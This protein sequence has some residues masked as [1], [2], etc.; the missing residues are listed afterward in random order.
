M[1]FPIAIA[2]IDLDRPLV[3]IEGLEGYLGVRAVVRLHG[4]P[5][6]S[7]DL[8]VINGRC[9]APSQ[10][11]AILERLMEPIARHLLEDLLAST[12]GPESGPS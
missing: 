4:V 12:P 6:G 7:L 9:P 10:R 5:I 2:D 3:S 1:L 11:R 8:P